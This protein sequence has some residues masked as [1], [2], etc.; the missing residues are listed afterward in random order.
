MSFLSALGSTGNVINM[1]NDIHLTHTP[2]V[3]TV[4]FIHPTQY[5]I[6]VNPE[7]VPGNAGQGTPSPSQ[8][9][10]VSINGISDVV[11][12]VTQLWCAGCP[13]SISCL[14]G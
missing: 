10:Y 6:A 12:V 4:L 8:F 7:P 2:L 3:R 5:R 14:L 1:I 11:V 13:S 9:V